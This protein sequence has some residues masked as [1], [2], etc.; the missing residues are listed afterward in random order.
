MKTISVIIQ[1]EF[2]QI[3]RNK[4]IFP[5]IFGVPVIQLI[6][7]VHAATFELKNTKLYVVDRDLSSTSRSL[8]AKFQG[9]AFFKISGMS[10]S[11]KDA[12]K[13]MNKNE[14]DMI[15]YFPSG[16]EKRL[17]TENRSELQL[18]IN[19][20]NG[21]TGG[22]INAYSSRII[23]DFNGEIVGKTKNNIISNPVNITY[24]HWYNPELNYK[25][26]MVPGILV[27][28]VTLVGMLLSTLNIVREK[29]LGTIEQINVTPVK[30]YQFIAGKMIPFW[31]LAMVELA[32]GLSIGKLFYNIPILGSLWLVFGVAAVFLLA[33]MGMGLL[34]ST[35]SNTQQQAMFISFFF[36]IIFILMGGLFTAIENMPDWAQWL[37]KI[38]PIAYFINSLRMILIKG[39]GFKDIRNDFFSLLALGTTLLGLAV[40]RY[41][42]VA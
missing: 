15:L 34:V 10:F 37:T 39:S 20:I 36:V 41:R 18:I 26:F 33:I 13:S 42:K 32:V 40:W 19:A 3:F 31:I 30:K 9:S 28:L 29:E 17:Y 6:I 4:A 35:V 1:K 38:N 22:L 2:R 16:F 27:I 24:T 5:L 7:L 23:S 8:T 14:A 21:M 11:V 25:I 12:E